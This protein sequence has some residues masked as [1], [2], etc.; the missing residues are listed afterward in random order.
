MDDKIFQEFYCGSCQGY[1]RVRLNMAYDRTIFM[2]CPQCK[3]EHQ[4][5][6]EKGQIVEKGRFNHGDP[7]EKLKPP[8]SAYSKEAISKKMDKNYYARDGVVIKSSDDL[9][10]D[11][12]LKERWIELY[13]D[14]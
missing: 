4:R 2:V 5:R 9:I 10:R 14:K 3:H 11:N 6:I 13:G 7:V 1:V 8:A 12:F